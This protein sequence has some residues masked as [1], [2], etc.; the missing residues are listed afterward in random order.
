MPFDKPEKLDGYSHQGTA[1]E[2]AAIEVHSIRWPAFG[3]VTGAG[4][5]ASRLGSGN[6]PAHIIVIPD[7]DQAPEG[8]LGLVPDL[9]QGTQVARR[10][11]ESGYHV[12]VP[13]L[14]D[15]TVAPRH[16]RARLT[17]R[18]FAYRPAFELGRHL[19][20]Y[21]VQKVLALVN[22]LSK[23]PDRSHRIGVFGYGE[24]GAIASTLLRSIRGSRP[25]ASAVTSTIAMMSGDSR[26]IATSSGSLRSSATPKS[27]R[28][29]RLAT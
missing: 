1:G 11:A 6:P 5:E 25:S 29:S 9:P 17:S 24:G 20:G 19:I 2:V 15:R 22:W 28:W 21:E 12:I 27:P 3:D 13:T 10:L 18:E 16:G 14:I 7:A 8:L 4:L 23:D 26:S